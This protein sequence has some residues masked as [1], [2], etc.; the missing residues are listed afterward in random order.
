M[1]Q[2]WTEYTHTH[3]HTHTHQIKGSVCYCVLHFSFPLFF[4][5]PPCFLTLSRGVNENHVII[6]IVNSQWYTPCKLTG[7]AGDGLQQQ[8]F[9]WTHTSEQR[10]LSNTSSQCVQPDTESC[11]SVKVRLRLPLIWF[12]VLFIFLRPYSKMCDIRCAK[13][14]YS[15]LSICLELT[16]SCVN[17]LTLHLNSPNKKGFC[18]TTTECHLGSA[19]GWQS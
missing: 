4:P 12:S 14:D 19:L 16:F 11:S 1:S 7:Q 15:Y 18:R 6:F 10:Q 3:T 2:P 8:H 13:V 9:L 17:S 5:P